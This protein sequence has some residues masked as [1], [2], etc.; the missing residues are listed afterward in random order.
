MCV[1][2]EDVG[3]M[4]HR[5]AKVVSAIKR[6]QTRYICFLASL[7]LGH[8]RSSIGALLHD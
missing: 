8:S 1:G 6:S 4:Y 7:D 3:Y 2:V 5:V